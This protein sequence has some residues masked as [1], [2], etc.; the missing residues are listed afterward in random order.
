MSSPTRAWLLTGPPGI[1]KSTIVT[2]VVY[3]LRTQGHAIGG[4][5]TREKREGRERVAFTM[6]D[7][8]SGREGEL[9]SVKGSLG[10]RVGRYRVNIATL[11]NIGALS[12]REAAERADVI[13]IDEIG[14]MELTSQD[15][16]KAADACLSSDK[17]ILAIIHEQM[18][19]PLID[20]MRVMDGKALIEVSLENRDKLPKTIADEILASLPDAARVG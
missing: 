1:G 17:P 10:P 13:V 7:L 18:K 3:L 14:P 9:A 19:D 2:R 8:M 15:F 20:A 12:L 11:A 16:R 5:L 4:C 6:S